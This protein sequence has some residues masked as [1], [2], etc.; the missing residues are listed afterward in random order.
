MDN[1]TAEQAGGLISDL[2]VLVDEAVSP[3]ASESMSVESA[4]TLDDVQFKLESFFSQAGAP[5]AVN[6]V[7]DGKSAGVVTKQSLERAGGTVA[8]P[9]AKGDIGTGDRIQ[10]PGISARY[11]LLVFTCARCDS[12]AYRIYYDVRDLPGC[13]HG[14]MELQ[15]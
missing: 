5:V 9:S 6:V 12:S 14:L 4:W 2:Q 15:L 13:E 3:P 1:D 7:V 10:L 8:E 11:R